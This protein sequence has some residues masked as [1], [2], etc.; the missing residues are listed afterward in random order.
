M[1][2]S[3]PNSPSSASSVSLGFNV[4]SSPGNVTASDNTRTTA[5]CNSGSI[6]HYLQATGFG[7]AVPTGATIDGIVVEW[8]R[9]ATNVADYASRIV[10]GGSVGSTDKSGGTWP[11]SDAYASYGGASDLWGTTWTPADIN[12]SNFGAARHH[13]QQQ[14]MC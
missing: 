14:G 6:T 13:Y 5:L 2:S 8:E 10:K 9:G 12:A 4:W 3:G 1:A 11:T 7:F